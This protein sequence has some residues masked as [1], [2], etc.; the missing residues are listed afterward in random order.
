LCEFWGSDGKY[1][2]RGQPKLHEAYYLKLDWSKAKT[3]LNW[4]PEWD[5][6][7]ALKY[8]SE[9]SMVYKDHGNIYDICRK[10]IESYFV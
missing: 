5:L 1:E 10:Q 4:S 3:L 2:V 9:W 6:G 8:V 7:T